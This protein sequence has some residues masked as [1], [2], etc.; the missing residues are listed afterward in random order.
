M[1][2]KKV[3]I[4]EDE[5]PLVDALT[6]FLTGEGYEVHVAYNGTEALKVLPNIMPDVILLDIVLPEIN[7]ITFLKSIQTDGSKCKDIPVIIFSNLVGEKT[8]IEQMGLR[9]NDY[10]VKANSSLS[11]LGDKL[12]T[13]FK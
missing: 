9:V 7:G 11:D 8:W 4:I 13:L 1:P 6:E 2:K 5:K 12:K 10:L 3:L